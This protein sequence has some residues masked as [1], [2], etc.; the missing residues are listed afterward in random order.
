M[1][2]TK[3]TQ[4]NIV[5]RL[6]IRAIKHTGAGLFEFFTI[7]LTTRY[8]GMR[9]L[10]P[11]QVQKIVDRL[12]YEQELEP[13]GKY[14]RL[15]QLGAVRMLPIIKKELAVD[16]KIRILVFDIPEGERKLRDRFRRHIKMLGFKQHQLSVWISRYKCEDWIEDLVDYHDV[17]GYVSLYVGEHIW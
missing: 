8:K 7:P 2:K 6:I 4:R 3:N 14:Y 10:D 9:L 13:K 12:I 11:R 15:T 5:R 16:G 17:E 1:P